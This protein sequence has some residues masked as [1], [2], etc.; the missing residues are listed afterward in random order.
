MLSRGIL[1]QSFVVSAAHT[2]A[3]IDYTIDA[4]RDALVVYRR[5]IDA[6]TVDGLLTGESVAPAIRRFAHPRRI[7]F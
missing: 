6:G 3:D 5:A 1:G 7:S 2:P 4:V